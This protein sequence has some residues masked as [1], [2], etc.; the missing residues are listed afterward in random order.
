MPLVFSENEATESGITY[1]D[2]TGIA[3]QYPTIYRRL[4]RPGERFVY[5]KGRRKR[6]GGRMPQ[7]YFGAGIVGSVGPDPSHSGRMVCSVL[8]YWPFRTPVPFKEKTG[9][10]FESG[11]ERRGYFQRGV[12]VIS[13][14]DLERITEAAGKLGS[15]PKSN[16]SY[17]L[18]P[19]RR[20]GLAYASPD[21]I[22]EV[23]SFAIEAALKEIARRWEDVR[24]QVQPRNNPGFDI[25][26][27][28][29]EKVVYVEVKGTERCI[30]QFF[31]TDGEI[32]FS[33][34][35]PSQFALLVIYG[36]NRSSGAYK[37]LWHDGAISD[38]TFK[39]KPV[40]WACEAVGEETTLST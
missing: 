1:E 28:P 24:V 39:L 16:E 13:E 10:Y 21:K 27:R 32:Q 20:S 31:I 33:V 17:P 37:I 12:R 5:Y 35:H 29:G 30:P 7:V 6:G 19:E 8:D 2:R 9:G 4:I 40:Q 15:D 18:G 25:L 26:V 14:E 34:R 3:Y 38:K 22:L 23:E 36:I 11:A